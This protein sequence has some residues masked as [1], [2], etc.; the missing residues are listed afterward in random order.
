MASDSRSALT[1]S[2]LRS[3]T[4]RNNSFGSS[5]TAGSLDRDEQFKEDVL[6]ELPAEV[7]ANM[8]D[9]PRS[10]IR[11]A[12]RRLIYAKGLNQGGLFHPFAPPGRAPA[13]PTRGHRQFFEP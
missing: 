8:Q 4:H 3:L 13:G 9:V 12:Y 2:S 11:P 5:L 7:G 1:I 6:T 10:I